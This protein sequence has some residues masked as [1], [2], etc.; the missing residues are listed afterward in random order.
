MSDEPTEIV[1]EKSYLVADCGHTTTTV[2][3]FDVVAGSYRLL[4]RAS[5]PTTATPPWSDVGRG[6]QQAIEQITA[7]TGRRLLNEQGRVIKP[8][9]RDG[10][11]V[12][13]FTAVFSAAP[14]LRT[15][16]VG[17]FD[18][19]SLESARRVL[20]AGYT[21]EVDCFSLADTRPEGK[22]LTLLVRAQP[23]L[24]FI[25]GGTDDGAEGRLL[26]LVELVELGLNL[27]TSIPKPPVIFAGNKRLRKAIIQ[28]LGNQTKVQ[29]AENVR[30][31]LSVEQ[32]ADAVKQVEEMYLL[33]KVNNLPGMRDVREWANL[34]LRSTAEGVTAVVQYLAALH[35]QRVIGVDVGSNAIMAVVAEDGELDTAVDTTLG[36]GRPIS[37]LAKRVSWEQ[38][39]RWLPFE[40]SEAEVL[41]FIQN[42]SL[43]P[44]TI[45]MIERELYMEQA[46]AREMLR[47]VIDTHGWHEDRPMSCGFLL[48]RGGV[49]SGA[50]RWGQV[51]LL[52]LDALQPTGIFP[53]ALDSYGIVPALGAIAGEEPMAVVQ[54][55]E[56]DALMHLGWVVAPSG[57]GSFGQKALKIT[58]EAAGSKKLEVDVAYGAL[59][60]LPLAPGQ[61]A[62]LTIRPG[63][64][65]DVGFGSGVATTVSLHG[66]QLGVIIDAR[67][68]PLEMDRR[69]TE[70]TQLVEKWFKDVGG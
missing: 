28:R 41:D 37:N 59:E 12:D 65:F 43:H 27:T 34:P 14:P 7:V 15:F 46:A 55:L 47:C 25:V 57:R 63:R 26:E 39:G 11:G 40:T 30:P 24:V 49:F 18:D 58:L 3:L 69:R 4:A 33:H 13:F 67:G 70:R 44:Q 51:A 31:R 62:K 8:M 9:R 52:L 19:V 6:I 21:D 56:N 38:I 50:G 42:K 32:L 1:S 20:A 17:L 16:L 36:M 10:S 66:G 2:A 5:T 64:R 48:A 54:A 29:V 68:R 53:I 60:L 23:D 45:P 35:E 61:Q 22:Q